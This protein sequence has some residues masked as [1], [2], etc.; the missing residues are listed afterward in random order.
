MLLC[1]FR[2]TGFGRS[3]GQQ[4][5]GIRKL[6]EIKLWAAKPGLQAARIGHY[7]DL[8]ILL[9]QDIADVVR[10]MSRR[11]YDLETK[12]SDLDVIALVYRTKRVAKRISR[13]GNNDCPG[14]Y[15][16]L[17]RASNLIVVDM[18]FQNV[19]DPYTRAMRGF[20]IAIYVSARINDNRA[21]AH[22]ISDEVGL[23][24]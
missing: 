10:C 9:V 1:F 21:A 6:P 2:A 7:R 16:Q 24:P 8:L 14:L 17:S 18:Y 11:L 5:L 20:H 23:M 13:A 4:P 12:R 3:I 22:F 19:R 15:R